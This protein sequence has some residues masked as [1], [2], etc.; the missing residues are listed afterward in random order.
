[1]YTVLDLLTTNARR[2]PGRTAVI[3]GDTRVTYADLHELAR[4]VGNLM[5][6][7]TGPTDRVAILLPR[8]AQ[9]LATF[10]GVYHAAAI[11]VFIHEQLRPRQVAHI[12]RHAGATLVCT[13][14][15]HMPLLRDIH[16]P[17]ESIV[18]VASIQEPALP[19]SRPLI[20][21]DVGALI[22][23]SGSTGASKGVT[24][25]HTNLVAGASIVADYL[26]LTGD[27]R[28]LAAL[29]WSFDYGLNQVLATFAAG[30]TVVIQRSTHPPDIS[31]TL[32]A[33]EVTGM[34]GVPTLWAAMTG[35]GSPL[36]NQPLPSLRYVTNSGGPLAP[37]TID[38]IRTAQPHTDLYL[39]Y[40]LTEAF[41]STYLD[42]ELVATRPTSIGKAIPNTEIL[43]LD[44][45]RRLCPPGVVGELVHRGPT[46]A[47][48]YWQDP[49]AT[50]AV[51]RP[52]PHPP[53]GAEL[54]ETVVYS[55]DYVRTDADGYLY[56]LGRR[57]EMF[58][59]RGVRVNA[60]EI[61]AELM[62]SGMITAAVVAA[63]GDR[64]DPRLAAGVILDE[65]GATVDDLRAYCRHELPPHMQPHDIVPMTTMP[66]TSSG[67]VA[68]AMVRAWL[69]ERHTRERVA[70]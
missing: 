59:S 48:G 10:F 67:K 3:D 60:T 69:V 15:R 62:A 58:K 19:A 28:T 63:T 32:V 45:H 43:V 37:V 21:P 40:G 33:A 41:R 8:G 64:S 31:R 46:V 18:D 6:R 54:A 56:Y 57:D 38:R 49:Q 50:A 20:G 7:H 47:L 13:T 9:T 26:Q 29:P 65:H 51:F 36:A 11:P 2:T 68:R 22:Y 70:P 66:T 12:I 24:V 53:A 30:A 52:H 23:T 39:M 14:G 34:A 35:P 4:R 27:D 55:G 44:E 16:L 17:A 25:T 61:E 42:P 5:A 1:M